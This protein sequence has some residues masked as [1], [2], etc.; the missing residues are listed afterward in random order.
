MIMKKI[1]IICLLILVFVFSGIPVHANQTNII[2]GDGTATGGATISKLKD[3]TT[4]DQAVNL[5]LR[6]IKNKRM[7]P[8]FINTDRKSVV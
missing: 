1:Q 7:T 4:A 3:A 8:E 2:L 5:G 6:K